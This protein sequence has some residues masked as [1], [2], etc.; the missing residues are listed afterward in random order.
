MNSGDGPCMMVCAGQARLSVVRM[1]TSPPYPNPAVPAPADQELRSEVNG[2]Y[3]IGVAG[4]G[5][6]V[7]ATFGGGGDTVATPQLDGAVFEAD[8]DV[9]EVRFGRQRPSG[10]WTKDTYPYSEFLY[11]LNFDVVHRKEVRMSGG[12]RSGSK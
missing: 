2:L 4:E 6:E 11:M 7:G 8:K 12:S 3:E 1:R 9:G 10:R 5:T